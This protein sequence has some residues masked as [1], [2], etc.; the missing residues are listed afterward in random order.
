[1]IKRITKKLDELMIV[2]LWLISLPIVILFK[3][4]ELIF[5]SNRLDTKK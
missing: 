1:M 4:I 3:I 2:L 5:K